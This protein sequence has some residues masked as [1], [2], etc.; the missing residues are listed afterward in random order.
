MSCLVSSRLARSTLSS[1][2][3]CSRIHLSSRSWSCILLRFSCSCIIA[4]RLR[5]SSG[6]DDSCSCLALK[7]TTTFSLRGAFKVLS[8][9][10]LPRLV[11]ELYLHLLYYHHYFPPAQQRVGSQFHALFWFIS[12]CFSRVLRISPVPRPQSK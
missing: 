3:S 1:H 10:K 8:L 2:S 4:K 9:P 6:W 7:E 5:I 11:I 12:C